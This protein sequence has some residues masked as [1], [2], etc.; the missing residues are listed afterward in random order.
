MPRPA[1]PLF[2]NVLFRAVPLLAVLLLTVLLLAL[3]ALAAPGPALANAPVVPCRVLRALPHDPD[4]FTQGLLLHHGL[5]LESVGGWGVSQARVVE[6]ETGRVLRSSPLPPEQFG[7]GLALAAGPGAPRLVQL[8]WRAGKAR[9]L[10]PDSLEQRGEAAYQGE[11]WGLTTDGR[12]RLVMS[13]GGPWLT[14]R[15]P[16]DF[17]ALGRMRVTDGDR[18]VPMLNE[19]EWVDGLDPAGPVILANVLGRDRIAAIDPDSGKVRFWIDC[20][21]LH[22]A[23]QRRSPYNVLNGIAWDRE[24]RRLFVT[25]KRWPAMFQIA[26]DPPGP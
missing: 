9:F 10:D 26:V 14:L 12:G 22:P 8:T 7:E 15:D 3:L 11:G 4:A 6:P 19:L 16:R 25:G 23:S 24:G 17:S 20:S 21:A 1:A 18:P 2:P 5:F 13:D